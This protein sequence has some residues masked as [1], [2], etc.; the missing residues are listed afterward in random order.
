MATCP[1]CGSPK[2]VKGVLD[3]IIEIGDWKEPSSPQ[4][5]PPYHYQVPLLFLPG[6]GPKTIS[7][8][9]ASF[10]TEMNVLHH[11][12]Y[13]ELVSVVGERVALTIQQARQGK[14]IF[15]PGGGGTYGKVVPTVRRETGVSDG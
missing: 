11:V 3:R 2:V 1:D 4:G 6:V 14:L 13:E 15:N 9:L 12:R 7:L 5:R 8:L 10:G